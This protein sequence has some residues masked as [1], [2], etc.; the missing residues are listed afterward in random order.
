MPWLH[1][2]VYC[3]EFDKLEK[4]VEGE[5]DDGGFPTAAWV[6][7]TMSAG[8]LMDLNTGRL[9]RKLSAMI[10]LASRT[11][12]DTEETEAVILEFVDK[13]RTPPHLKCH[14][15]KHAISL[16]RQ[17]SANICSFNSFI[18]PHFCCCFLFCFFFN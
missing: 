7:E 4:L 3:Q 6:R 16:H 10:K 17:R 12:E 18:W 11:D 15:L 9:A 2:V 13:V 5:I 14:D 8:S 1:C